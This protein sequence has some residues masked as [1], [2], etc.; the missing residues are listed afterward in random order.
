M[1]LE[2]AGEVSGL[3]NSLSRRVEDFCC[4]APCP[5]PIRVVCDVVGVVVICVEVVSP[6]S[7]FDVTE[8][9]V[10]VVVVEGGSSVG[11][12][13]SLRVLFAGLEETS[14]LGLTTGEAKEL[15]NPVWREDICAPEL[16][17]IAG[18]NCFSDY[19]VKQPAF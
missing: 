5:L 19:I 7:T 4:P 16:R 3:S 15:L 6:S 2:A 11:E 14:P 12:E 10:V 1:E 9:V 8:I 17:P 18:G 13:G